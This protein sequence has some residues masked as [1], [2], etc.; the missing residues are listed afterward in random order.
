MEDWIRMK[1]QQA[2]PCPHMH[3]AYTSHP[4]FVKLNNRQKNKAC[5]TLPVSSPTRRRIQ[6]L[7]SLKYTYGWDRII[8]N[9]FT[10]WLCSVGFTSSAGFYHKKKEYFTN[11]MP[12]QTHV[13]D[14]TLSRLI[15]V[16]FRA[17]NELL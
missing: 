13:K 15:L 3:N 11:T 9:N 7:S 5:L 1:K 17:F 12:K 8:F 16:K 6:R 4:V 10:V 14:L 2:H